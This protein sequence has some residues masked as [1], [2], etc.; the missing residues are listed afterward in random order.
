M[1]IDDFVT[2]PFNQRTNFYIFV[3]FS[4]LFRCRFGASRNV[5][6]NNI[7]FVRPLIKLEPCRMFPVNAASQECPEGQ[8]CDLDVVC[9]LMF[10]FTVILKPKKTKF[11]N[12]PIRLICNAL[13]W[14]LLHTKTYTKLLNATL[15][16]QSSPIRYFGR[17]LPFINT[18]PWS[19]HPIT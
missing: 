11:T 16:T 1:V 6:H 3:Y 15:P 17:C 7:L 13:A 14:R 9:H 8:H 12:S 2:L 4:Y 19:T 5:R 18:R 10:I